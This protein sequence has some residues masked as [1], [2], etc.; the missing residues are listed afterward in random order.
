[1]PIITVTIDSKTYR[2]SCGKDEEAHLTAL[3]ADFSDRIA[4]MRTSFGEIGDMRLH[5]MAALTIAD[6][7]ADLRKRFAA[8]EAEVA[9]SRSVV[10]AAES[11]RD[12]A[13]A[14]AAEGIVSAAGRIARLADALAAPPGSASLAR[15]GDG[16]GIG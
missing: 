11:A 12:E 2:M 9:E 15:P 14:R 8:L 13:A 5:V 1:M 6:E 4:Q 7:L 16:E 3:S 10:A